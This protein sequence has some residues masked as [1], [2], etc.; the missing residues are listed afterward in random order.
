MTFSAWTH[1]LIRLWVADLSATFFELC[2]ICVFYRYGQQRGWAHDA[3]PRHICRINMQRTLS[4]AE[5]Q[6]RSEQ[7]RRGNHAR[8]GMKYKT[9]AVT[10][11]PNGATSTAT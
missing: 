11:G 9:R 2:D 8:R 4:D 5:R 6:R 1:E 7:A 10:R 3:P